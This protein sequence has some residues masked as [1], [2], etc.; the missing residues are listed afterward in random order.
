MG[1]NLLSQTLKDL[2]LEHS[3]LSKR[4]IHSAASFDGCRL[5]SLPPY[6][7]KSYQHLQPMGAGPFQG[8]G[9]GQ[10]F[11]LQASSG[12]DPQPAAAVGCRDGGWVSA[13]G[14]SPEDLSFPLASV[15]VG[16]CTRTYSQNKSVP[17]WEIS[18]K[19]V[20][21]K[22]W[23]GSCFHITNQKQLAVFLG[24]L[25]FSESA[26]GSVSSFRKGEGR[27]CSRAIFYKKPLHEG[28]LAVCLAL[29]AL[30]MTVWTTCDCSSKGRKN[31][32]WGMGTNLQ[33][34]FMLLW[35][36]QERSKYRH[37]GSSCVSTN[38]IFSNAPD[39]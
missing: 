21:C 15:R 12:A 35:C 36:L 4:A 13:G 28:A 23:P 9:Q 33:K 2:H 38:R 31:L 30:G 19:S 34:R 26:R 6:F 10:Q 5:S 20:F 32:C 24:G 14:W 22:S 7:S 39:A 8:R 27:T 29:V 16:V 17:V 11:G 25:C 1:G 37:V 18:V 3:Q